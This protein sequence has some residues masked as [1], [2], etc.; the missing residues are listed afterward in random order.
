[1]GMNHEAAYKKAGNCLQT[2]CNNN[3]QGF[4]ALFQPICQKNE[5]GSTGLKSTLKQY[6]WKE[7]WEGSLGFGKFK[8]QNWQEW[9]GR[10][11]GK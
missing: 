1:M 3:L 6:D 8:R 5:T 9:V 7:A 10:V 4:T 2:R 11:F